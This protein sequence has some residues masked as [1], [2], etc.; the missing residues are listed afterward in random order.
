M[1]NTN[2]CATLTCPGI[3]NRSGQGPRKCSD[4]VDSLADGGGPIRISRSTHHAQRAFPQGRGAHAIPIFLSSTGSTAVPT[5]TAWPNAVIRCRR[6][7]ATNAA[8]LAGRSMIVKKAQPP[9]H[10]NALCAAIW[11]VPMEEYQK[12]RTCGRH[13]IAGRSVES[14]ELSE[15]IF[16]PATRRRVA[17]TSTFHSMKPPKIVGTGNRRTGK[18]K[19]GKSTQDAP[20]VRRQRGIIIADTNS[21]LGCRGTIDS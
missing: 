14:S 16:T 8:A 19:S 18:F 20:Q 3:K 7:C 12:S 5:L 21:S 9:R 11:R 13:S 2:R 17:T 15:P 4:W 1:G 10:S 6:S